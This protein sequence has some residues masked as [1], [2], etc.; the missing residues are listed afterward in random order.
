MEIFAAVGLIV[1]GEMATGAMAEHVR[2]SSQ[3]PT[4]NK[5][6]NRGHLTDIL[7]PAVKLLSERE[8]PY[9]K[10]NGLERVNVQLNAALML[11]SRPSFASNI[12]TPNGK[13][14][15]TASRSGTLILTDWRA[16]T[17]KASANGAIFTF[18]GRNTGIGVTPLE[19]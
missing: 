15:T 7:G 3:V 4:S 17:H 6:R 10:I 9:G 13:R 14:P 18:K 2:F 5:R 19:D 16:S 1:D 12:W 11:C 8:Y